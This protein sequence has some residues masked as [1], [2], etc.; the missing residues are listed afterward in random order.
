MQQPDDPG[1]SIV[2]NHYHTNGNSMFAKF[3]SAIIIALAL[4]IGTGL[5]TMNSRLTRLETLM[6][7]VV[8]KVK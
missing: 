3:Q 4:A 6:E 7:L 1:Q 2:E 8:T 5:W